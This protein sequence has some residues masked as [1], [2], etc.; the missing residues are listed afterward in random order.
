MRRR[1][2]GVWVCLAVAGCVPIEEDGGVDSSRAD[3]AAVEDSGAD[4]TADTADSGGATDPPASFNGCTNPSGPRAAGTLTAPLEVVAPFTDAASTSAAPDDTVDAYDCAPDTRE[5]GPGRWYRFELTA[6]REVRIEVADG[7]GVDVDVHLLQDPQVRDGVASGCVARDDRVVARTLEAGTWWIAVDTWASSDGTE[8]AGDYVLA[9][10]AWA[11]GAW[12]DVAV[13]EGVTW[14]HFQQDGDDPQ[15]VDA[16]LLDP[17]ALDIAPVRHD[18]CETVP[19]VAA[20]VGA[21]VGINAAFFDESCGPRS[22]LRVDGETLFRPDLGDRQ[23]AALW[24]ASATPTFRWIDAGADDTSATHGVGSYPSLR[25]SGAA[26]L[27]PDG[28]SSF[29]TA[30]HPRTGIGTLADGRFAWVVVDGRSDTAGGASLQEFAD[31][32][33]ELGLMDA[34][35]LDGGGSSTMYLEGCSVSGVVNFPSDGGGDD[36]TGARVVADGVYAWR[37]GERPS[38]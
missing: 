1:A 18:G 5:W 32:L 27:D 3:S 35:N 26:A 36:H 31:L 34:V 10:E 8:H 6:P 30:R 38:E 17:S 24:D 22:F 28:D 37:R 12:T 33:G 13:A 25:A 15:R 14:R 16:V 11:D 23:R 2:N 29:F 21:R 19:D 20:Q 9:V 4:D 7:S